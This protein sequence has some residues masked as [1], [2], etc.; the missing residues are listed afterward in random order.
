MPVIFSLS[1]KEEPK[2][3][4]LMCFHQECARAIINVQGHYLMSMLV[5][6]SIEKGQKS[7]FSYTELGPMGCATRFP[8]A[9]CAVQNGFTRHLSSIVGS[10]FNGMEPQLACENHNSNQGCPRAT[11]V[12]WI[13]RCASRGTL[14]TSRLASTFLPSLWR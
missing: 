14:V 12:E 7:P 8:Q 2:P 1:I 3:L 5:F 6:L 9:G 13:S 4:L 10:A 11:S